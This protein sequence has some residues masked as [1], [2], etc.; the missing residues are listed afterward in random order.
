MA[1]HQDPRIDK[2]LNALPAWQKNIFIQVRQLIHEAEPE[3]EET[4]KRNDWPFFVLNGN[5]CAFQA[6]KDHA[7]V[8]IYDPLAPD[9]KKIVTQGQGNA[10]GRLVQIYENQPL[11]EPAF[12]NLIKSVADNNRAGGW[13]KLKHS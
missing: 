4:I 5:V 8:Y 2:Y 12:K 11:N 10:T 3:I 9:P 1:D 6:T 13:R 7:N